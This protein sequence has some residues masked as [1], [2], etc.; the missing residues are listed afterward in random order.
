MRKILFAP[1]FLLT[2]AS[3][4]QHSTLESD[5]LAVYPFNINSTDPNDLSYLDSIFQPY[6]IFAL[7][8]YHW[9]ETTLKEEKIFL[10]YLTH[11]KG[12]D[13]II[14]ERPYA[15]G[16]WINEYLGTGDTVLLKTVTDRF[17]GFDYYR[18]K[19]IR[20]VNY[21][22]FYKWLYVFKRENNLSFKVVGIDLGLELKGNN[23][24]FKL[25][26]IQQF[27]GKFSLAK[28]FPMSYPTLGQLCEKEDTKFS[29]LKKWFT[30]YKKELDAS[31]KLIEERLKKDY[32]DFLKINNGIENTIIYGNAKSKKYI[33]RERN[34]FKNF[35]GEID[36]TDIVYAQFGHPHLAMIGGDRYRGFK[37]FG[38][39]FM[40]HV[41]NDP[42]FASK[43]L[44]IYF[45]CKGCKGPGWTTGHPGIFTQEEYDK[46]FN[47]IGE[48]SV[49]IDFRNANNSYSDIHKYFQLSIFLTGD[50]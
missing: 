45:L 26:A 28:F 23:G 48:T 19:T 36:S 24:A 49:L 32:A 40:S 2:L 47:A 27:I 7:A 41:V 12:L 25:W 11:T 34:M 37:G 5:G 13:K 33:I 50:R 9:N 4:G 6:N 17:W 16:Y 8:E 29:E 15:Y 1:L 39:G 38:G 10:T 42:K 43:I 44:S 3:F 14:I 31:N 30:T 21:Y 18:E 46:I 20:Y 22:E 35:I